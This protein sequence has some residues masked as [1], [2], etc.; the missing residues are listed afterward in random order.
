MNTAPR[1]LTATVALVALSVLA[2]GSAD[3]RQPDDERGQR[4]LERTLAREHHAYPAPLDQQA[5]AAQRTLARTLAREYHT[6]LAPDD[7]PQ[8]ASPQKA[9]QRRTLSTLA[10]LAMTMVLATTWRRRARS[11]FRAR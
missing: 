3:A 8:P 10:V 2:A 4:A 11:R 7:S 1:I 6:Y 9:A 5:Q